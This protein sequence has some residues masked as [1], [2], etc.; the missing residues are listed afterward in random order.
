[1]TVA[2]HRGAYRLAALTSSSPT[3]PQ[4]QAERPDRHEH[5]H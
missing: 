2:P 4:P 5:Q 1:M 3:L